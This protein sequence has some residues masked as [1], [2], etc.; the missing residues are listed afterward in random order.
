[1]NISIRIFLI[2]S[3]VTVLTFAFRFFMAHF[4][5]SAQWSGNRFMSLTSYVNENK[6]FLFTLINDR[7]NIFSFLFYYIC[8]GMVMFYDLHTIDKRDRVLC[9]EIWLVNFLLLNQEAL[10][11]ITQIKCSSV[12]IKRD[13]L[14]RN[15]KQS[16]ILHHNLIHLEFSGWSFRM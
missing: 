15:N 10:S 7:R 9:I 3:L 16:D 1:M 5:F 2:A 12:L 14:D 8:F 11:Q 13:R 4:F 6:S